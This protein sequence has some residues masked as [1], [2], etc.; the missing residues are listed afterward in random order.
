MV[1][2]DPSHIPALH[3]NP[4]GEAFT[5]TAREEYDWHERRMLRL[6]EIEKR[7]QS[8][9]AAEGETLEK[10]TRGTPQAVVCICPRGCFRIFQTATLAG[11]F[12]GGRTADHVRRAIVRGGSCGGIHFR[13]AGNRTVTDA[14]RERERERDRPRQAKPSS[15]SAK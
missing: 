14:E 1:A 6:A 10:T 11:E 3:D 9:L 8:D 7:I 5:H 12:A 15:E 4:S 13:W 2:H